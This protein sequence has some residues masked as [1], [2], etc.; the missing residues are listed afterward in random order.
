MLNERSNRFLNTLNYFSNKT[1]SPSTK[2]TPIPFLLSNTDAYL[3]FIKYCLT[4]PS[5][6]V[7][8]SFHDLLLFHFKGSSLFVNTSSQAQSPFSLSNEPAPINSMEYLPLPSS[9]MLIQNAS[10]LFG[11]LADS[12]LSIHFSNDE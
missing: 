6:Q 12:V 5:T 3:P 1:N 9:Y 4:N 7:C 10:M 11:M 2:P 8:V